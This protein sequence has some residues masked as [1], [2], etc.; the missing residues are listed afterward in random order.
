MMDKLKLTLGNYLLHREIRK[1]NRKVVVANLDTAH[2]IGIVYNATNP[3]DF[4]LLK[5]FVKYLKKIGKRVVALGYID[6]KDPKNHL[7]TRLEFRFFTK[8]E[9]NWVSKPEGL[10]A[11]NF[12]DEHFDVLLDL[13]VEYCHPIKYICGLSKA[14]FKVGPKDKYS[15]LYYDMIIDPGFNRTTENFISNI[16]MYIKMVNSSDLPSGGQAQK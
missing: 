4:K 16:D 11:K 7:N 15:H 12:L 5:K 2:F 8:K 14:G 9:L 6:D 13:S 1:Q 10:E 3:D